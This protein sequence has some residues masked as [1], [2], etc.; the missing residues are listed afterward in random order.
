MQRILSTMKARAVALCCMAVFS[1]CVWAADVAGSVSFVIGDAS[2][3]GADGK[4][5]PVARGDA[6]NTGLILTTGASGHIHLRMIDGAF[7]SVRPQSRL[8]IESYHYD[9]AVPANNR[10]KLVLDQGVVRSITGRAGEAAKENYRLN[11][12]LAAIGIRGTDFVVQASAD[13]TRVAVQSGAVVMSPL[14]GDCSASS[15]GPCTSAASRVLTAAMQNAYLELRS[16][17]DIPL[18]VPAEKAL[19]SPNL[20]AP[21]RPEE[22]RT[23]SDKQSKSSGAVDGRDAVRE[24]AA[25]D[26]IKK[27]N[28]KAN[29][30]AN[31]SLLTPRPDSLPDSLPV[32][33]PPITPKIWWGRWSQPEQI[34]AIPK[35]SE[36]TFSVGQNI[37]ALYGEHN[38]LADFQKMPDSGKFAFTLAGSDAVMMKGTNIVSSAQ[39]T[40]P[41]FSIDFETKRFETSLIV[42]SSG[43]APIPVQSSGTISFQGNLNGD[44]STTG[45]VTVMGVLSKDST[46]AGYLF[47]RLLSG[48]ASVQGVTHWTR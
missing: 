6:I 23:S 9:A 37:F 11:T 20:I 7:V 27:V 38:R 29:E 26:T 5:A 16:R 22:P 12:P 10:I 36:I 21:A 24:E 44:A 18:L 39:I 15:I 13:V 48:D 19:E 30:N 34:A 14:S 40:A 1:S 8:L 43:N 28:D 46:Q 4:S 33:V 2:V 25:V 41:T 45:G 35:G 47:Q 42:T 3:I 31:A 17:S 32:S